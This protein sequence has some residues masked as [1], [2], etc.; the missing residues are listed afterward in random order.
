MTDARLKGEWLTD[1][2]FDGM[3]DRQWRVFTSALMWSAEQGTDGR[4]L[5]RHLKMLHPEG[6]DQSAVDALCD[7]GLMVRTDEGVEFIGWADRRQLNQSTAAQVESYK[8]TSRAKQQRYRDRHRAGTP[9]A[10]P[11]DVREAGVTG[12]VYAVRDAGTSPGHVGPPVLVQEMGAGKPTYPVD[13]TGNAPSPYCSRHPSGT[14]EPCAP[15]GHARR[16][17]EEALKARATAPMTTV[18]P[19]SR[20][21]P[22]RHKL[23]PD[24]SCLLC[25]I[26]PGEAA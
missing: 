23:V 22:G 13:V 10:D 21:T 8:A 18:S 11:E 26:R 12:N 3:T 9:G 6:E 7:L 17:F 16:A 2:R 15:C 25:D 19:G 24:G 4:I 20:C 5:R 14:T 1:P